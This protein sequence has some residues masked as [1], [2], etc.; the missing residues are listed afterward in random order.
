MRDEKH[1]LPLKQSFFLFPILPGYL[2]T[3]C[4]LYLKD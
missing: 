1:Y 2:F 4:L 3:L